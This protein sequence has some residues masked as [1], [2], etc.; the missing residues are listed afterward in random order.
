MQALK[1]CACE[2][3]TIYELLRTGMVGGPAQGFTRYHEKDITLIRSHVFGEKSKLTK[4]V[5][6]YNTNSLCLYCSGDKMPCGREMVIVN[7]KPFDQKRIA[8]FSND[9]LK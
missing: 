1:R 3:V 2:K 5:I 4:V 7:N 9:I 8:K 6:G